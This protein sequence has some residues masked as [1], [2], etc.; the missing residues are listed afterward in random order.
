VITIVPMPTREFNEAAEVTG[1][2]TSSS[3][4]GLGPYLPPSLCGVYGGGGSFGPES[5]V[6]RS[7]LL[8]PFE[9]ECLLWRIG[10]E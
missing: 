1:Y 10:A 7:P 6:P 9:P 3:A 8:A 2:A 4:R 5:N